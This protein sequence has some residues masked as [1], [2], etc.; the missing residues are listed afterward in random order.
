MTTVADDDNTRDWA[1]DCNG[2]GQELAVR[3]V[4]DSGVVMMAVAVEDGGG[5][6]RRQRW[7]MTA[8]DNNGMQYWVADYKENEQGRAAR[9][10]GDTEWQWRLRR[11]IMA[12]V[13]VNGSGRW[14]RQRQTTTAADDKGGGWWR[15]VRLGSG[16]QGGRRRTAANNNGIRQKADK[17]AGQRLWKNKEL[18]FTQKDFFQQY[19]LPGWIFHSRKNS[20]CALFGLSV[21]FAPQ[22]ELFAAPIIGAKNVFICQRK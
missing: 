15:H 19:S 14:W 16:L 13:E 9:D 10:G 6:Q 21:L 1:A 5:G 8:A 2:E 4:G 22:V 18:K 20:Q 7:T 11:R 17:P 12:A 3:D